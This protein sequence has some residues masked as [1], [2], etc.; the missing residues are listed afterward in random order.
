MSSKTYSDGN[1]AGV[2]IN[3]GV[4]VPPL[5]AHT[6]TNLV[7]FDLWM[8]GRKGNDG[9]RGVSENIEFRDFRF[10]HLGDF[11]C[12]AYDCT[13]GFQVAT[14]MM[15]LC[16]MQRERRS[17]TYS[18]PIY[19]NAAQVP[20]IKAPGLRKREYVKQRRGTAGK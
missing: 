7:C 13:T 8:F 9:G 18:V 20:A 17:I 16:D 2:R 11:L 10:D 19:C 1:V 6:I 5:F 15:T 12:C 4:K 14:N 3:N